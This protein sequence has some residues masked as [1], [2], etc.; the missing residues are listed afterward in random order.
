[1]LTKRIRLMALGLVLAMPAAALAQAFPQER[2]RDRDGGRR[3]RY[4]VIIINN[5]DRDVEVSI[6]AERRDENVR[7]T[8]N[9]APRANTWLVHENGRRIRVRGTDR[10]KVR[11]D[12][13][14][15]RISEV[16]DLRD[17]RWT[18]SVRD[19]VREQRDKERR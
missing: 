6:T 10:I 5:W 8:W 19:V 1:M 3:E 17:G 4:E 15:V 12:M 9:I 18:I 13:R 14:S 11:R 2:D 16:G 7:E